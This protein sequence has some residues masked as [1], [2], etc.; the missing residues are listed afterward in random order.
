VKRRQQC[1]PFELAA[2]QPLRPRRLEIRSMLEPVRP[3]NARIARFF[4]IEL[5]M[6]Q[7]QIVAPQAWR[8]LQRR[9]LAVI[10][11]CRVK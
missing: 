5:A 6:R 1:K 10:A 7:T 4:S 9:T 11:A 3:P 2:A 8:W